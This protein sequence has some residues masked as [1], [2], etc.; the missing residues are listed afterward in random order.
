MNHEL[1]NQAGEGLMKAQQLAGIR[2]VAAYTVLI[3]TGYGQYGLGFLFKG[4]E[5]IMGVV[6]TLLA[7][8]F[9]VA[10]YGL[11][12]RRLWGYKL[13]VALYIALISF[14]VLRF[15][16]IKA[17]GDATV[18]ASLFQIQ[19]IGFA[20]WVLFYLKK[21][22]VK[23]WFNLNE[24]GAEKVLSSQAQMKEEMKLVRDVRR[25]GLMICSFPILIVTSLWLS[26]KIAPI[27]KFND[28]K[29][30]EG[31]LIKVT[32]GSR[33]GR[34]AYLK[35]K[36][37]SQHLFSVRVS[38]ANL[39][40][41][42]V[43]QRVKVWSSYDCS[44][45]GYWCAD[46]ALQVMVSNKDTRYRSKM[47]LDYKVVRGHMEEVRHGLGIYDYLSGGIALFFLLL[48]ALTIYVTTLKMKTIQDKFY[49]ERV[50][51]S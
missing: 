45:F 14:E 37:D 5:T 30:T 51:N 16:V 47:I 25:N 41:P 36:E 12:K 48:G 23:I 34:S 10:T 1:D 35:L 4:S 39:Y 22:K 29:V 43:S 26:G 8:F 31:E 11:L 33:N 49:S 44:F 7:L 6:F 42:F 38:R 3:I 9:A 20:A 40:S 15:I 46:T 27:P 32:G 50:S 24:L 17:G 13:T 2:W 28:L 21:E 18:L 19:A